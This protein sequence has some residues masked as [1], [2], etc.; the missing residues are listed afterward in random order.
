MRNTEFW[1]FFSLC[2]LEKSCTKPSP[3]KKRCSD[4]TEI[5]VSNLEN[6]QP[7]QSASAKQ[8]S[9]SPVSTQAQ[10]PDSAPASGPVADAPSM[11]R[12][13]N[14]RGEAAA[15]SSVKTRMQ[16]LAAQ[17]RHWDNSDVTG[18]HCMDG[19]ALI[20]LS[21]RFNLV[22]W[23][24]CLSVNSWKVNAFVVSIA[25][26]SVTCRWLVYLLVVLTEAGN[27]EVLR[28]VCKSLTL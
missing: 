15:A 17:R 22:C 18:I 25:W 26:A 19:M 23:T 16:K 10:P 6:E 5:E 7:V 24:F 20:C 2:N 8:R 13:Q 9:P 4:N 21:V 27:G 12:G 1:F 3:S 14:S 28:V 11:P